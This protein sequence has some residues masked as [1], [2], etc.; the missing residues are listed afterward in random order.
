MLEKKIFS[1]KLIGLEAFCESCRD[2]TKMYST[3]NI[4]F[5]CEIKMWLL[6]YKCSF[7]NEII[8]KWN[9]KYDSLI[10]EALKE[11]GIEE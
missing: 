7:D 3:G 4:V 1:E 10:Q 5:D 11:N 6:E 8:N 2:D 9:I